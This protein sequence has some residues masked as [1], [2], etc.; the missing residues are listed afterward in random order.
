MKR[1]PKTKILSQTV[2]E[3]YGGGALIPSTPMTTGPQVTIIFDEKNLQPRVRD[4]SDAY[5]VSRT[6][7]AT[8]PRSLYD[9]P[10]GSLPVRS[11]TNHEL[12]TRYSEL[13]EGFRYVSM[14]NAELKQKNRRLEKKA[15]AQERELQLFRSSNTELSSE[16]ITTRKHYDR[17]VKTHR[18]YKEKMSA[19]RTAAKKY[20]I[21]L[22]ARAF[23]EILRFMHDYQSFLAE[24]K[25]V[26]DDKRASYKRRIADLKSELCISRNQI[27]KLRAALHSKTETDIDQKRDPGIPLRKRSRTPRIS[28]IKDELLSFSGRGRA[29]SE[30]STGDF[31]WEKLLLE[32]STPKLK[33]KHKKSVCDVFDNFL[34]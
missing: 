1:S 30:A 12:E 5:T 2:E 8:R 24:A 17:L 32:E 15:S 25:V 20:D 29:D 4:G 10:H 26:W 11:P 22:D 19:F 7:S 23:E 21:D 9:L 34:V 16:L 3:I 6:R 28:M 33:P 31:F 14:Q 13:E 27:S 18:A